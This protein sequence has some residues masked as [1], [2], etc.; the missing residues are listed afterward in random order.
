MPVVV[1]EGF[2]AIRTL[3]APAPTIVSGLLI[4]SPLCDPACAG[5]AAF[6]VGVV[7]SR[8]VP[9]QTMRVSCGAA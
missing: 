4:V 9:G 1:I 3:L 8:Y 7:P 2:G 6:V 5:L